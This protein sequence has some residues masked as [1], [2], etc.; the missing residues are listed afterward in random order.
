MTVFDEAGTVVGV[1]E[2]VDRQELLGRVHSVRCEVREIA[3]AA[4]RAVPTKKADR[5]ICGVLDS[6]NSLEALL[7][8]SR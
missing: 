6:L 3:I 7:R 2:V 1:P 5:L 4:L 8:V